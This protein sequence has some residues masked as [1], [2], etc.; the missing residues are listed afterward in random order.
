MLLLPN[1]KTT[2]KTTNKKS[3][4]LYIH[5]WYSFLPHRLQLFNSCSSDFKRLFELS[6]P[7]VFLPPCFSSGCTWV[8]NVFLVHVPVIFFH[9][10]QSTKNIMPRRITRHIKGNTVVITPIISICSSPKS[11]IIVYTRT[12]TNTTLPPAPLRQR[13]RRKI[14]QFDGR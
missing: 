9:T 3:T 6:T 2:N 5:I 11:N 1:N 8:A 12:T 7:P 4:L 14:C 10:P 13:R